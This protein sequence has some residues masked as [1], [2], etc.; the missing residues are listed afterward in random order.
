[1][2]TN[3]RESG[4][5]AIIVDWL[6]NHNGFEQGVSAEYNREYAVDETHLFRFLKATQPEQVAKLGI[7]AGDT[8]KRARFL[9]RLR[10]HYMPYKEYFN[11]AY[12]PFNPMN[13]FEM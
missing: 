1:M 6:V 8:L 3:T 4:L 2:P 11:N 7:T 10:C 12:N 5:E 13:A 9:D